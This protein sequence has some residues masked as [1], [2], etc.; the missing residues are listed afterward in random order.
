LN[1]PFGGWVY[2]SKVPLQMVK[3]IEVVRGGTSNVWGSS[4][5]GGVIQVFTESPDEN[6]FDVSTAIG[7]NRTSQFDLSLRHNWESAGLRLYGS[8][9]DTDGY[10]V[11]REDQRGSIDIPASSE[12]DNVGVSVDFD[13]RESLDLVLSANTFQE[14][15]G[16]GTPLTGNS[17]E[18]DTASVRLSAVTRGGSEWRASLVVHDQTFSSQF[19]SQASDRG[20]ENPALNQ[21]DVPAEAVATSL[22]WL[23]PVQGENISHLLT[24]GGELRRTEGETNEDFFFSSGSFGFRRSAGGEEELGGFYLQDTISAGDNLQIQIGARIDRWETLDGSRREVSLSTGEARRDDILVD[25]SETQVSPRLSALYSATDTVRIR[26]SLYESFRAPTINEL[27][28]PFRVRSD[29][30]EANPAL[31]PESLRGAEVGVDIRGRRARGEVTVFHNTIDDPI[32]NVTIGFGPGSV[33]PCGFVPGGGS[34]RQRQNLGQSRIR[35]LEA[36]VQLRPIRDWQLKASFLRTNAKIREATNQ[37]A[38]EGK[39]IAQ[40]PKNQL[41]LQARYANPAVVDVAI[42]LRLVSDQ[43]E[44]DLN[45]R[46]L[47][48]FSVVD[49]SLNRQVSES[50]GVFLGF[51]NVLDEEVEVGAASNGLVAIGAPFLVHAGLRLRVG[52]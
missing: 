7:S 21:F 4:A 18:S 45:T 31:V 22:Q 43:W 44:D 51:E 46:K 35:G 14:D 37:P 8:L 27:F 13:L 9:F 23:R 32:A 42:Q 19:S 30:T 17:T 47:G 3:R 10:P 41:V 20:S 36:E 49:V 34:C 16:N 6:Q 12:H 11:L 50:F 48:S 38:L 40:V 5:L 29:I 52:R 1:D 26:A 39:L 2:W 24:A 15:R 25:R 33:V 28:R